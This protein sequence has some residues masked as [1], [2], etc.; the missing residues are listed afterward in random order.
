[1]RIRFFIAL[2]ICVFSTWGSLYCVGQ[3]PPEQKAH[4]PPISEDVIKKVSS[5]VSVNVLST[6]GPVGYA[7]T[8]VGLT[9]LPGLKDAREQANKGL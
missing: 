9:E 6:L 1:M 4:T 3:V 5:F 7:Y 2:A 8:P